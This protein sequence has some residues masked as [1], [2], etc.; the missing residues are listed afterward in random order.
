[1]AAGSDGRPDGS[2]IAYL[3]VLRSARGRGAARALLHAVVA[4]AA[5]RGRDRVGLEVDA[6]SPTGAVGL[7]ESTGFVTSYVTQ[8]W[9][10]ALRVGS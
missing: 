3:G 7:Y 4:D 1:M 8:S 10:R 6:D 9:H 2:Y 5:E